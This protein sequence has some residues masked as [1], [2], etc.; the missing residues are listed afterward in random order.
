ML[1]LLTQTLRHANRK[2]RGPPVSQTK[3]QVSR[4]LRELSKV[5]TT[6]LIRSDKLGD[7]N[8]SGAVEHIDKIIDL[9]SYV[10]D[11]VL[12]SLPD[13]IIGEMDS[14]LSKLDSLF[15]DMR[16]FEL[17]GRSNPESARDGLVHRA[18]DIHSHSFSVLA[19]V[20]TLALTKSTDFQ[21]AISNVQAEIRATEKSASKS[22]QELDEK[23]T[24]AQS[25]LESMQEASAEAGVSQQATFFKKEAT[26][27][28][29]ETRR[30]QRITI[31]ASVVLLIA[32]LL[33]LFGSDVAGLSFDDIP[34][35]IQVALG[36]LLVF[37]TL[38]YGVYLSARNFL[39]NRH[40]T[41]VNRHRYNALQTYK[42]LAEA[43][44]TKADQDVVLTHA[45]ACI[46]GSQPTGFT[47]DSGD[48]V[49]SS[50]NSIINLLHDKFNQES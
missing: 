16:S 47:K 49:A 31:W 27:H 37:G 14:I 44:H 25:I 2:S 10:Q 29:A 6:T 39:A 43:A 50:P 22:M 17:T 12:A 32:A 20:L 42:A 45:A 7:L 11:S 35:S 13:N 34:N 8:F 33:S 36:K 30:W 26:A 40:N 48:S 28:D 3:Q 23:N 1:L 9:L 19:P 15:N 38:S 4:G 18:I 46:F 41:I 24:K 5:D 21:N